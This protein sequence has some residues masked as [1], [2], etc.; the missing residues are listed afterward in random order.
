MKIC[1]LI[2]LIIGTSSFNNELNAQIFS[3]GASGL[4]LRAGATFFADGL[5]L[6]PSADIT[7]SGMSLS[8]NSTVSHA[9]SNPY[10]SRVYRFS[11]NT[12][13]YSGKVQINYIDPGELNS[14]PEANLELNVHNGTQWQSISGTDNASL[15]YVLRN[16]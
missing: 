12:P 13:A 3:V 6:T 14:I 1:L 11:A 5:I 8:R 7:L 16:R 10:I 9:T 15:N 2:L 4:T